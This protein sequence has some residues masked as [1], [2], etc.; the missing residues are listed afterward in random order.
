MGSS[1]RE[2]LRPGRSRESP[3]GRRFD[4]WRPSRSWRATCPTG[5]KRRFSPAPVVQETRQ[6]P[7]QSC[8]KEE[9]R[10]ADVPGH[11]RWLPGFCKQKRP[12]ASCSSWGRMVPQSGKPA[13][14]LTG[15]KAG[16][17]GR[18]EERGLETRVW[19]LSHSRR[20]CAGPSYLSLIHI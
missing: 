10:G 14:Q 16:Q 5:R 11:G 1:A 3:K 4:F 13:S 19:A 20:V 12:G 9:V 2:D 17:E 6:P 7:F 18:R 8:Q 15:S